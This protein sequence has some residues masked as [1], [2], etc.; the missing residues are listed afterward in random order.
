M[1]NVD[2]RRTLLKTLLYGG[3]TVLII[4]WII[5]ILKVGWNTMEMW[6]YMI[7][8]PVFLFSNLFFAIKGH[9]IKLNHYIERICDNYQMQL[10]D[11]FDF[12]D[13][14]LEELMKMKE[15]IESLH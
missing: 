2:N 12:S 10:Y 13:N 14:E 7:G 4:G 11:K 8:L 3:E 6:T 5:L 1:E 15:Q 9:S